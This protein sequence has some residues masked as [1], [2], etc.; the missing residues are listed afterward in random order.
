MENRPGLGSAEINE[1]QEQPHREVPRSQYDPAVLRHGDAV[2]RPQ[3]E[4]RRL[5]RVRALRDDDGPLQYVAVPG[6]GIGQ[7]PLR[8][9]PEPQEETSIQCPHHEVARKEGQK[10]VFFEAMDR[11]TTYSSRW[12][13]GPSGSSTGSPGFGDLVQELKAGMLEIADAFVVNKANLSGAGELARYLEEVSAGG[14]FLSVG[15]RPAMGSG[16]WL[17]ICMGSEEEGARDGNSPGRPRGDMREEVNELMRRSPV[18]RCLP[19]RPPR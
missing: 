13:T 16:G 19:A 4:L 5:L 15:A 3:D 1:A 9:V 7:R 6:D 12:G 18:A 17:A 11:P 8:V 14:L 2:I 10:G